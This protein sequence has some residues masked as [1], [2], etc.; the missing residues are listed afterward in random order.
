VTSHENSLITNSCKELVEGA[1]EAYNNLDKQVRLL[2]NQPI[3]YG[4]TI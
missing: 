1:V 2:Q 4:K 3:I